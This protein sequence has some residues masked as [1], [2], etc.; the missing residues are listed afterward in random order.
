MSAICAHCHK[1]FRGIYAIFMIWCK[2]DEM[3]VCRRCWE[4]ECDEGHGKGFKNR[5][6]HPVQAALM[7]VVFLS[8]GMGFIPPGIHDITV[9]NS[10]G[11]LEVSQVASLEA[12]DT[13]RIEGFINETSDTVAID[14][15][16]SKVK[17]GYKWSWND[18]NEFLF[19]DGTGTI[20]VTTEEWYDME[21]GAHLAPDRRETDG[22]V[23]MGG[24]DV[25]I[26]GDVVSENGDE[27][28][29]LRWVGYTDEGI[30]PSRLCYLG[31][32]LV[33]MLIL[34]PI[35][36]LGWNG[37]Q[38]RKLHLEKVRH[39]NPH[40]IPPGKMER[41]AEIPWR[42]NTG[43]PLHVKLIITLIVSVMGILILIAAFQLANPHTS[44]D[45]FLS[46]MILMIVGPFMIFAPFWV[47]QDNSVLRPDAVG[48]TDDGIYFHYDNPVMQYLRDD[49]IWWEEIT[50]IGYHSTGKS[51]YWSIDKENGTKE[52]LS[53]L[54]GANRK[55]LVNRWKRMNPE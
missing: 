28:V 17:S 37:L 38:Q 20:S 36:Y 30:A 12:G 6:K 22:R 9:R 14:G 34:L 46:G 26:I 21:E 19:S 52:Y 47:L 11:E 39:V 25:I 45:Y 33:T 50:N 8:M 5:S 7:L 2:V 18:D 40:Q 43:L 41:E 27:V 48:V 35:G 16:E 29:Y 10:W 54:T 49:F 51:G 1:E 13:I 31:T 44:E 4:D 15:H 24:D 32:L 3:Y 42:E 23:Y 53:S 55:F